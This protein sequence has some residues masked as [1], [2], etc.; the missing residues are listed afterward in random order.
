MPGG[1]GLPPGW[2]KAHDTLIAEMEG[3]GDYD[4]EEMVLHLRDKF[5]ELRH[6]SEVDDF[7]PTL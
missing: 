5:P 3:V 6:V 4:L 7:A 1:I 2:G